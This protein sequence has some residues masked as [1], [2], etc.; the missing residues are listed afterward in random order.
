MKVQSMRAAAILIGL[1]SIGF[2][3]FM[4]T[5][6]VVQ[7]GGVSVS[8]WPGDCAGRALGPRCL[9]Y[10]DLA[11]LGF[12]LIAGALAVYSGIAWTRRSVRAGAVAAAC[13]WMPGLIIDLATRPASVRANIMER[14][15]I[16]IGLCLVGAALLIAFS[17]W[18]PEAPVAKARE[19]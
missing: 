10:Q 12:P 3:V 7:F 17:R 4:L 6:M 18:A 16:G 15:M 5:A 14:N 8:A 1:A 13:M 2:A 9:R 19:A 11:Y